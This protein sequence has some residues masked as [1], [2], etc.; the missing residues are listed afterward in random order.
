MKTSNNPFD[1]LQKAK[2]FLTADEFRAE[3]GFSKDEFLELLKSCNPNVFSTEELQRYHA[4]AEITVYLDE[5]IPGALGVM[6]SE[7]FSWFS[8]PEKLME[9]FMDSYGSY[10]EFEAYRAKIRVKDIF[11][12]C[13]S[14]D[15]EIVVNPDKLYDIEYFDFSE[16]YS[17]KAIPYPYL[18]ID[19]VPLF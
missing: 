11:G 19:R 8:S 13:S 10:K 7:V 3:A 15:H 5:F 4:E 14:Y 1:T 18:G 16:P 9:Y 2:E 17:E 12:Y 6:P